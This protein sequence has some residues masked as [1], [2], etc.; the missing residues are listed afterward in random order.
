MKVGVNGV[1]FLGIII[2]T[3]RE[4]VFIILFDRNFFYETGE[5]Y[6]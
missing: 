6:G 2:L 1:F 5:D 3:I 4:L